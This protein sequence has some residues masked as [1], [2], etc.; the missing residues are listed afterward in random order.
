MRAP[1]VHSTW[2][3]TYKAGEIVTVSYTLSTSGTK[4]VSD[5]KHPISKTIAAGKMVTYRRVVA[6]PINEAFDGC[7]DKL[8]DDKNWVVPKNLGSDGGVMNL[9][10]QVNGLKVAGIAMLEGVSTSVIPPY[11]TNKPIPPKPT[12]IVNT[13]TLCSDFYAVVVP[14]TVTPGAT[15]TVQLY[16]IP[17]TPISLVSKGWSTV[18][19][20]TYAPTIISNQMAITTMPSATFR[21]TMFTPDC[22]NATVTVVATATRKVL[23]LTAAPSPTPVY[24]IVVN[25]RNYSN[26]PDG[27]LPFEQRRQ[28]ARAQIFMVRGP[29]TPENIMIK[30]HPCF[31]G[32]IT[33][34]SKITYDAKKVLAKF[35]SLSYK[36]YQAGAKSKR[37]VNGFAKEEGEASLEDIEAGE[38]EEEIDTVAEAQARI[39]LEK[40]GLTAG[41]RPT[42]VAAPK[43]KPGGPPTTPLSPGEIDLTTLTIRLGNGSGVVNF[44]V[45]DKIA[46]KVDMYSQDLTT[47]PMPSDWSFEWSASGKLVGRIMPPFTIT[48]TYSINSALNEDGSVADNPKPKIVLTHAVT[49][50]PWWGESAVRY[51]GI[52][53]TPKPTVRFNVTS[54]TYGDVSKFSMTCPHPYA[55]PSAFT[56]MI[57]GTILDS[58]ASTDAFTAKTQ[59]TTWTLVSLA[60][61]AP[62]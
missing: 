35:Y 52:P 21:T 28:Q 12:S 20:A 29:D 9:N 7:I 15:M 44:N 30:E 47:L 33:V 26:I 58:K 37:S 48:S 34:K 40:R 32:P 3:A 2:Q 10:A 6:T 50:Q 62:L 61:G 46:G 43:P 53:T 24:Q 49:V 19:A 23:P 60:F 54:S 42:P 41:K 25:A 56:A 13:K 57:F 16:N 5:L 11:P 17:A 31:L 45:R 14:S 22:V 59:K 39:E 1:P 18:Y 27:K 4:T 38:E 8:V 55:K 51:A 36:R